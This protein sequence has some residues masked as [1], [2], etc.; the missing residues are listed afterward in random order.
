[1]DIKVDHEGKNARIRLSG[2]F[3]INT[4][5]VFR[6]AYV[7]ILQQKDIETLLIDFADVSYID[8]SALGMLLLLRERMTT[9]GKSIELVN[10]KPIVRDVFTVANFF[11]L[12][13]IK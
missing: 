4:H 10:C 12:F 3:D 7:E 9:A 1:M 6:N 5:A 8:S 2:R 13:T 11:K